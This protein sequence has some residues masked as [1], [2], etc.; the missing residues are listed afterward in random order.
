M[1]HGRFW[2]YVYKDRGS[3]FTPIGIGDNYRIGCVIITGEGGG[4][5]Y[6]VLGCEVPSVGCRPCK[7][8]DRGTIGNRTSDG[9]RCTVADSSRC[10][11]CNNRPFV[12]GNKDRIQLGVEPVIQGN[13]IPGV[14]CREYK[15]FLNRVITSRRISS[16][17]IG[18]N[19]C[20]AVTQSGYGGRITMTD[21]VWTGRSCHTQ[22]ASGNDN[23]NCV[24]QTDASGGEICNDKGI[25]LC[26]RKVNS[27][28]VRYV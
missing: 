9:K 12:N 10:T 14:H 26:S 6:R 17:G 19:T 13:N 7:S 15:R 28:R 21:G 20:S 5:D 3:I 11:G 16:P 23:S 1:I 18:V 4:W 8:I 25:D 27:L 24:R 22:G 2:I